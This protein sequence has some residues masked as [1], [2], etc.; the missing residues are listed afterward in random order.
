[1]AL[2]NETSLK[3]LSKKSPYFQ[4]I[5]ERK[6]DRIIKDRSFAKSLNKIGFEVFYALLALNKKGMCSK[7]S[8]EPSFGTYDWLKRK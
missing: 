2:M 6:K 3:I 4:T 8:K 1:M 5:F 7:S